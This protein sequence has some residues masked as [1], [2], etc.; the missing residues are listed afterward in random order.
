MKI[1]YKVELQIF[2]QKKKHCTKYIKVMGEMTWITSNTTDQWE[3]G[4]ENWYKEDY[5]IVT[6]ASHSGYLLMLNKSPPN[7]L[8]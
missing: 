3:Y 4:K 8:A 1:Y 6:D 7:S 2:Q 5:M